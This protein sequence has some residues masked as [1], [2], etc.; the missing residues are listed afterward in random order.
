MLSDMFS[1]D[2]SH[3]LSFTLSNERYYSVE[4]KLL[5]D[6]GVPAEITILNTKKDIE[7]QVDPVI[8][9]AIET[10]QTKY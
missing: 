1:T 4:K 10:I 5:E 2:L 9:K 3:Q 7:L 8:K 6:A